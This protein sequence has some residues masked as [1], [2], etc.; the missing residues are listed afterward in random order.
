MLIGGFQHHL[1][2][3]WDVL[4]AAQSKGSRGFLVTLE[5]ARRQRGRASGG[6]KGPDR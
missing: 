2:E 4:A 5:Q 3:H 1:R 6:G